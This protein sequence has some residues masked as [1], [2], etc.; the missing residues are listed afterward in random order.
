MSVSSTKDLGTRAITV[1]RLWRLYRYGS[2][3]YLRRRAMKIFRDHWL[4]IEKR[5]SSARSCCPR[6]RSRSRIRSRALAA[7]PRS[8]GGAGAGV[9]SLCSPEGFGEFVAVLHC[10]PSFTAERRTRPSELSQSLT[11]D[12]R[13]LSFGDRAANHRRSDRCFQY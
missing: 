1:V 6:L 2:T 12:F 8:P 13:N 5:Y 9:E 7:A 10:C 11:S 3:P 4:S